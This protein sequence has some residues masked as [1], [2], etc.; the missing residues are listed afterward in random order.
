[1]FRAPRC[2]EVYNV[3]G[4]RF[5]NCS[6]LEAIA[7]CESIANRKLDWAY[8]EANRAGDHVWY[9]SDMAKFKSHYPGWEQRYDLTALLT[10]I[11]E[12][13]ADR[14]AAEAPA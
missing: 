9:V 7:L 14:W 4:T 3:G 13:N 8:S 1:V 5:S 11:F 2:G 12:K 6:M 10:E